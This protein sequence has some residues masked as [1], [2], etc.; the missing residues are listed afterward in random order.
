[1]EKEDLSSID[2]SIYL[3]KSTPIFPIKKFYKRIEN[4]DFKGIKVLIK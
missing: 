4:K 1:M 3:F 2:I